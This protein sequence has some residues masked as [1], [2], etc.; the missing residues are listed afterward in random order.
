MMSLLGEDARGYQSLLLC[1]FSC[2]SPSL[3]PS[4]DVDSLYCCVFVVGVTV[5]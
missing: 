5:L 4:R 1:V 2:F 3:A